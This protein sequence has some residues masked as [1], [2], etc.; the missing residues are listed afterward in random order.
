[1]APAETPDHS[2]SSNTDTKS[3]IPKSEEAGLELVVEK[4]DMEKLEK[5]E[6]GK[7]EKR[8]RFNVKT[9]EQTKSEESQSPA[10]TAQSNLPPLSETSA[11]KELPEEKR[12]AEEDKED[13]NEQNEE[14]EPKK[15]VDSS[16]EGGRYLKY[17]EEI[18][19]GSFK[20][21]YK[22]EILIIDETGR[23]LPSC[24]SQG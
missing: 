21:V 7:V 15:A 4:Q 23:L 13:D 10:V 17:D 9:D 24:P 5:E 22:G 2:L 20:T 19:R 6:E 16:P 11:M 3:D 18:G 1:M 12:E 14:E 8:G